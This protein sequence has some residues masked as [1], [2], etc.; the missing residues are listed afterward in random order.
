[1]SLLL[2]DCSFHNRRQMRKPNK[3]TREETDT[4]F[5]LQQQP[6][7]VLLSDDQMH[8]KKR[9]YIRTCKYLRPS[10]KKHTIN[11]RALLY[12]WVVL[13]NKKYLAEIECDKNKQIPGE[14]EWLQTRFALLLE[15]LEEAT[16]EN[17]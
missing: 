1:M 16:T 17:W 3:I 8:T 5:D 15:N 7:Q 12:G 11:K 6:N 9:T 10:T 14:L 13:N 2:Y 4:G